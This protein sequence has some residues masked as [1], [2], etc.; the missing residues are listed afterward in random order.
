VL[1]RT[2]NELPEG[3]VTAPKHVGAILMLIL[4]LF[5]SKF[6]CALVV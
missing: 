1:A 5:L 2:A 6:T 3:G 4:V